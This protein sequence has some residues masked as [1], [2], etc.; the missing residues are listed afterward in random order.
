[1]KNSSA[2]LA[3]MQ[4]GG[5]P[6][7]NVHYEFLDLVRN[8][9]PEYRQ[10]LLTFLRTKYALVDMSAIV[11]VDGAAQNFL[12]EEGNSLFPGV[13]LVSVLTPKK[14]EHPN[15]SRNI[16]QIMAVPDFT[17]T[18]ET[19]HKMFPKAN[20]VLCIIG[21]SDGEKGIIEKAVKDFSKFEH[22]FQFEITNEL[23]HEEMMNRVKN[24]PPDSLLFQVS[25]Y[26][27][28]TG[29]V[30][31]PKMVATE[32]VR[33]SP[34][35]VL[36]TYD[37]LL[38]IGVLGGSLFSYEI[39][40]TRSAQFVLDIMSGKRRLQEP[41]TVE[42]AVHKM[43]FDWNQVQRW[44][45]N[46][47]AFPMDTYFFNRPPS[48]WPKYKIEI[49]LISLFISIQLGLIIALLIQKSLRQ[50]LGQTLQ[51]NEATLRSILEHAPDALC[52]V[53]SRTKKFVSVN[54]RAET[55]FGL[56]Q[57]E[58][59]GRSPSE[60]YSKTQPDGL[61]V[62]DSF[63]KNLRSVLENGHAFFERTIRASDGTQKICEVNLARLMSTNSN[64]IR[65]SY[66]DVTD[67]KLAEQ[68]K[69]LFLGSVS[70]E[71]RTPL[72]AIMGSA[73]LL[74]S[75]GNINQDSKNLLHIIDT[76]ASHL[77]E[78][79]S[80]LLDLS[81]SEAELIQLELSKFMVNETFQ[82]AISMIRPLVR[83]EVSL[84]V[85]TNNCDI[86]IH[87]DRRKVFQI[88]LNI[89]GNAA[90]FTL[91]GTVRANFECRRLSEREC[92]LFFC[93]EDTGIGIKSSHM[94]FLFTP[95]KQQDESLS[96]RFQ[97]SGLGLAITKKF[98]IA[99]NGEIVVT[100]EEQ[101]GTKVSIRIPVTVCG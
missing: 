38:G 83:P 101:K 64:H 56:P 67:R 61:P 32:V 71:L 27:D 35:P 91:Q 93:I 72:N 11:T 79:V 73:D 52:V 18:L 82:Q 76:S 12:L 98:L 58:I 88:L 33:A 8:T 6:A 100:S 28:A 10:T 40:G 74:I 26:R 41:L 22:H 43:M 29:K 68:A 78:L 55:I 15:S 86:A 84:E 16:L 21:A 34:V 30:F 51:Q 48:L 92:E 4:Q 2:F 80:N 99:L 45:L 25:F 7:T 19:V 44:G 97:G 77:L 5:V 20:K 57:A 17:G 9:T 85:V 60:F 13:P 50:K 75:S 90:K 42:S 53:D 31:V 24:L 3:T 65:V 49:I 23:S 46:E 66:L 70:H 14:I 87:S 63:S 37:G 1:M 96:R 54:K 69:A 62:E 94:P 59:I 39:E 89:L 36:T 47:S 95:F 81:K